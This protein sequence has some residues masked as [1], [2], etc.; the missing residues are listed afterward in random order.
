MKTER[1][2]NYAFIPYPSWKA[3]K[4]KVKLS[5][6]STN[7]AVRHEVVWGSGYTVT[8]RLTAQLLYRYF[9]LSMCEILVLSFFRFAL[10]R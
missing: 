3:R 4:G 2:P 8:V 1:S 10:G 6:C 7:Q 9:Y 5:L